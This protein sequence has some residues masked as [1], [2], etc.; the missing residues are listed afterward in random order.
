MDAFL[1]GRFVPVVS[2][3]LLD[4]IV[5]VLDRPRIRSRCRFSAAELSVILD[6]LWDRAIVV[7]P[8]GD[9]HLCRDPNDD[10]HL[11]A[12]I[13]GAADVMVSCDDD[14]KRDLG[15]IEQLH[16]QGIEV[17]TVAQ[18]VRVLNDRAT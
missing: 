2:R 12:A 15:L 5:E 10:M 1:A 4:E 9:L 7:V 11:E 18:F 17:L 8:S 16:A 3:Y 13:A 14:I 6:S